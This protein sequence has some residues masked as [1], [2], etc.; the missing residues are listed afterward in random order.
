MR[1]KA[2]TTLAVTAVCLAVAGGFVAEHRG[3]GLPEHEPVPSQTQEIPVWQIGP[4]GI[5]PASGATHDVFD[6]V[7]AAAH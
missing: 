6:G 1:A 5:R 4:Q 7:S 3:G 2:V